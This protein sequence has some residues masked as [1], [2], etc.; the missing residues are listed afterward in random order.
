MKNEIMDVFQNFHNQ[1]VFEKSL[2]ASFLALIRKKVDAMDVKD[3]LPISLFGRIYKIISKVSANRFQRVAH[4][5][6]SDSQNAFV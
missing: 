4:G 6:I 1:A 5:L 2:N 3:F